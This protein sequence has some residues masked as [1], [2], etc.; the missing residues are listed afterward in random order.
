MEEATFLTKFASKV[1]VIHRRGELRA[2]RI[3]AERAIAHPNIEFAWHSEVAEILGDGLVDGLHLRDLRSGEVRRLD[4]QGVF[5][6]I[7]HTPRS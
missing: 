5:V 7:G 6:A 2:S 1:T 3:M 4:A